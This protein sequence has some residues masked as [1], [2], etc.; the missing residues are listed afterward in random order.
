MKPAYRYNMILSDRDI[1]KE[2]KKGRISIEPLFP[3]AIQPASVDLHL[4]PH[5]LVFKTDR[6]TC[7]DPRNPWS[8]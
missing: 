3:N 6:H 8:T 1:K 2:L 7:I 4:G 5:F